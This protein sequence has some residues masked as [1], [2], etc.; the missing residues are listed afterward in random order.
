MTEEALHEKKIA[1]LADNITRKKETKLVLIAGP[2]SSGKTTF[3]KRLAVQLSVNGYIPYVMGLDD[4]FVPRIETPKLPNGE[5]D[6]ESIMAL[7]IDLIN[8][9][10]TALLEGD[11]IRLPRYN[12]F[13][14]DREV[15]NHTLR[16]GTDNILIIEGIHGLNE[17][18]TA[19]IPT[20][21]KVKIYISALNQLNID[22]HNRIPTTDCR[23]IRRIVRDSQYRGYSAEETLMRF[24]AVREGEE[25]NIFP[26]QEEADYI[27]NSTLTF[28]L[29]VLKKYVTPLLRSIDYRSLVY[30]EAQD[31]LALI[32]HF[33]D[34][35]DELVPNNSILRE[36]IG[37]SI[38][39][40]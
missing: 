24:P 40:Y 7:D 6:F 13:T 5:Y 23:K 30:N 27:F 22:N 4:Y 21:N 18:L 14:G 19:S 26:F 10:L 17:I 34:I 9:D 39:E 15:S 20:E 11:E 37:G 35:K 29:A 3:A 12:F 8:K 38:F 16:L 1:N 33:L 31:L 28:E 36:F 25:K 2:S 32:E